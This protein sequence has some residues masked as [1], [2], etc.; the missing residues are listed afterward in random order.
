MMLVDLT[1]RFFDPTHL[2]D[3]IIHAMN[4]PWCISIKDSAVWAAGDHFIW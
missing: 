3:P 2:A 4:P 1:A